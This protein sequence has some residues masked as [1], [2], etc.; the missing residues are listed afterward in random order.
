MILEE[1]E[2]IIKA[3]IEQAMGELRRISKAIKEVSEQSIV[4]LEK[5]TKQFNNTVSQSMGNAVAKVNNLRS[6][7]KSTTAEQEL[8]I[9]KMEFYEGLI[10]EATKEGKAFNSHEV[11]QYRV[12][13]EKLQNKFASVSNEGTK[14]GNQ[15]DK[16]MKNAGKSIKKFGLLLLGARSVFLLFRSGIQM[17]LQSNE[18]LRAQSEMTSQLLGQLFVPAIKLALNAVQYLLI[19]MALL[20]EMFTGY[21]AIA[22]MTNATLKKMGKE[23]TKTKRSLLG[24]DEITNLEQQEDTGLASGL[25]AQ[26][27]AMTEFANKVKQVKEL[28]DKWNVQAIVNKLK[29][30]GKW[31]WENKEA[32]LIFMGALTLLFTGAKLGTILTGIKSLSSA[33]GLLAGA[34]VVGGIIYGLNE[35]IKAAEKAEKATR[36]TLEHLEKLGLI[37]EEIVNDI[38][39]QNKEGELTKEQKKDILS[40]MMRLTDEAKEEWKTLQYQRAELL[41]NYGVIAQ[42]LPQWKLIGG[43]I[44]AIEKNELPLLEKGIRELTKGDWEVQLELMVEDKNIS[45]KIKNTVTKAMAGIGNVFKL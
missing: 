40:R 9:R 25:T 12:E 34:L 8:L 45:E 4:P 33:L 7:I 22:E 24:M 26:Q 13:L 15:I 5:A 30:L 38:I 29:E 43:Q 19:G 36:A 10:D 37:Q 6:A 17:A 3:N 20:V 14:T 42:F 27:D 18:Q 2:I 39:Q 1:L 21:N 16:S 31:L 44:E 41:K 11:L 32:V 35:I 28:F 23:A